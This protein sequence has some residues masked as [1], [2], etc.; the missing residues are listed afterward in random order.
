MHFPHTA[1]IPTDGTQEEK[2]FRNRRGAHAVSVV[3]CP[4]Q[5][6]FVFFPLN[7][8]NQFVRGPRIGAR[9][10]ATPLLLLWAAFSNLEHILAMLEQK[11]PQMTRGMY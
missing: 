7:F 4:Q 2:D 5:T 11:A 1:S 6:I 9:T 8:T 10:C 3:I